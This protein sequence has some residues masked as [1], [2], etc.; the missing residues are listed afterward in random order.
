M[1]QTKY[2]GNADRGRQRLYTHE[3][4]EHRWKQSGIRDDVRPVTQ[5]EGQVTWN[6]RRVTFQNETWNSQDKKFMTG[7][8]SPQCDR[9]QRNITLTETSVKWLYSSVTSGDSVGR[10]DHMA[11]SYRFTCTIV[12]CFVMSSTEAMGRM[13]CSVLWRSKLLWTTQRKAEEWWVWRRCLKIL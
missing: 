7:H 9:F 8:P 5:E 4:G 3:G 10:S 13:L 11:C 12:D 6:K 2:S 1:G